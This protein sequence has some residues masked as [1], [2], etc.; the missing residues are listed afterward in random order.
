MTATRR[1][2]R[3]ESPPSRSSADGRR[4]ALVLQGGAALGAY[5]AGVLKA[6]LEPPA[7]RF[8]IVTGCSMGAVMAAILVGARGDPREQIDDLWQRVAMPTNPFVPGM[9]ANTFPTPGASALY[10]MNPMYYAAAPLATYVFDPGPLQRAIEEWVDFRRL[11]RAA[12]ELIVTAVEVRTG[13]LAEFSNRDGMDIRHVMASA[14]LPPVFPAVKIDDGEY[15]DGGL[16]S[17]TPLRPALNAIELHNAADPR[18]RWEIIVVD[19]FAPIATPPQDF[20]DVL[21]RAFELAFFGKF[22]HDLKLFEMYN[23]QI[24]LMRAVDAALPPRSPLRRHPAFVR[25]SHHRRVDRLTVIHTSKPEAMG[26]PADFSA[27]SIARRMELGYADARRTLEAA[28]ARAGAAPSGR[29]A[30]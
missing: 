17:N 12:T 19:L 21:Q 25:M 29:V 13:R 4:T 18:A 30:P 20:T 6:L 24:D 10:R 11:R 8:D 26:G 3:S 28:A 5:E 14:S 23:A 2:T 22:Q 16:I 7:R 1:P 15:W 27:E 9:F